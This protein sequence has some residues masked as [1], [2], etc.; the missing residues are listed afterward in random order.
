MSVLH[1][2][3]VVVLL[4]IAEPAL[5]HSGYPP[6]CCSDRDCRPALQGE[7]ELMGDG[8]YLVVPTGEIFTRAQVRPSFDQNFHRCLYDPSNPKSR[9]LCVLVPAGT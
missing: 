7:I 6:E 5:A 1:E 9:S 2:L 4:G 3:C 8:R